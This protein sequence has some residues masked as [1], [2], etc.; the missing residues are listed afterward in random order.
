M[1]ESY[2]S[3]F[4]DFPE[5]FRNII[6]NKQKSYLAS[7]K[8][9][10]PECHLHHLHQNTVPQ[11]IAM[12]CWE[13]PSRHSLEAA[14]RYQQAKHSGALAVA[15]AK[16]VCGWSLVRPVC[17]G[18]VTRLWVSLKAILT[19]WV[20]MGKQLTLT[21]NIVMCWNKSRRHTLYRRCRVWEWAGLAHQ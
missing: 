4:K 6:K 7:L 14:E 11:N 5:I 12:G 9:L 15:K 2:F 17:W 19:N 13:P 8:S 21:E 3:N 18:H 20:G 10:I 1:K 16:V